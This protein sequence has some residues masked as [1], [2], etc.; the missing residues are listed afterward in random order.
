M[1]STESVARVLAM[2]I[3]QAFAKDAK[4]KIRILN[5]YQFG[6]EHWAALDQLIFVESGWNPYA[7]NKSSGACGIAQSL[8]CSKVLSRAGTL[9]NV[10]GQGEWMLDYIARAY[11]NPTKA[12]DKWLS[13]SPHWY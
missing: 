4:D 11:G 8:P 1:N 9:D 3:E 10:V 5:K 6:E 2:N 13:R 7:V 12:Y